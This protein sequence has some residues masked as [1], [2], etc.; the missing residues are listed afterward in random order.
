M[1]LQ[2]PQ[3]AP[4]VVEVIVGAGFCRVDHQPG[5]RRKA[6]GKDRGIR[7]HRD[8]FNCPRIKLG[9]QLEQVVPG[10]VRAAQMAPCMGDTEL[11]L[12]R[13][14]NFGIDGFRDHVVHWQSEGVRSGVVEEVLANRSAQ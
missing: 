6:L 13:G 14:P 3:A 12:A 9:M 5:A 1:S 2:G 7:T 8:H 10:F 11:F 4:S